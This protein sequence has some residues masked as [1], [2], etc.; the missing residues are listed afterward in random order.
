MLQMDIY[1]YR[2]QAV[3]FTALLC[4]S[5]LVDQSIS[6]SKVQQAV[7]ASVRGVLLCNGCCITPGEPYALLY[8]VNT[9]RCM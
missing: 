8:T 4:W 9:G 2:L 6:N 1:S 7:Q 3:L 5:E